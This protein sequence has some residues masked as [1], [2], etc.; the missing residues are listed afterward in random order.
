MKDLHCL[1]QE[2]FNFRTISIETCL[3]PWKTPTLYT[4]SKEIAQL[5]RLDVGNLQ[6][7]GAKRLQRRFAGGTRGGAP[8]P[9]AREA[10]KCFIRK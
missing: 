7:M 8:P 2:T 4:R 3:F 9:D 1:V 10:F 6:H 5:R